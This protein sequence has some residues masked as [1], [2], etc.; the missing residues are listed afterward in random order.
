MSFI[1]QYISKWWRSLWTKYDNVRII[2]NENLTYN[3]KELALW[4]SYAYFG[5][6]YRVACDILNWKC[7]YVKY[8]SWGNPISELNIDCYNKFITPQIENSTPHK[9]YSI[10]FYIIYDD[11]SEGWFP[12]CETVPEEFHILGGWYDNSDPEC[13]I[14]H[15]ISNTISDRKT[16]C[17]IK[18]RRNLF[19][20]IQQ[21][22]VII[23]ALQKYLLSEHTY[24]IMEFILT[25][26]YGN[27][28][29]FLYTQRV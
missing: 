11:M 4:S 28:D 13:L 18:I 25:P 21:C 1:L 8:Y 12:K 2:Y 7:G 9:E 19:S 3:S 6:R 17:H 22:K 24:I 15:K 5:G 10:W 16:L 20:H 29:P 26:K 23:K 27:S 14:I